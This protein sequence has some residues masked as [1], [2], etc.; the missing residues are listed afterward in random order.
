MELRCGAPWKP[1]RRP[2]DRSPAHLFL[3]P[4]THFSSHCFSP[5]FPRFTDFSFEFLK[6][7]LVLLDFSLYQV[8]R[9]GFN[10]KLLRLTSRSSAS[11]KRGSLWSEDQKARERAVKGE[12]GWTLFLTTDYSRPLCYIATLLHR[13]LCSW[14]VHPNQPFSQS[15]WGRLEQN[16]KDMNLSHHQNHLRK[17]RPEKSTSLRCPPPFFPMAVEFSGFLDWPGKKLE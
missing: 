6:E 16:W 17:S 9:Q 7:V 15:Q 13:P 10:G 4:L 3:I 12:D 2:P 11:S 8:W 5:R 14:S 1:P